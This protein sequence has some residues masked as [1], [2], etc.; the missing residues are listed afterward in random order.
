MVKKTV[1]SH[2]SSHSKSSSIDR[3]Y[4]SLHSRKNRDH[5]FV[6]NANSNN[7]NK[8]KKIL[9]K[10]E[11]EIPLLGDSNFD[12]EDEDDLEWL[13]ELARVNLQYSGKKKRRSRSRKN[14][15]SSNFYSSESASAEPESLSTLDFINLLKK[16]SRTYSISKIKDSDYSDCSS[17]PCIGFSPPYKKIPPEPPNPYSNEKSSYLRNVGILNTS[18]VKKKNSLPSFT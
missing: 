3:R 2:S 10:K 18:L 8:F 16:T 5:S 12:D 15:E 4:H 6:N 14:E 1:R 17:P 13:K 11:N 9:G 7:R